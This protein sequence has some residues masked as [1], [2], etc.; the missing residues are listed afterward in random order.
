MDNSG[1]AQ[2]M[3]KFEAERLSEQNSGEAGLAMAAGAEG[4]GFGAQTQGMSAELGVRAV[5]AGQAREAEVLPG[6]AREQVQQLGWQVL[7]GG[8]RSDSVAEVGNVG[9]MAG[10]VVDFVATREIVRDQEELTQPEEFVGDE[11][12]LQIRE[13]LEEQQENSLNEINPTRDF[14][15]TIM[16]RGQEKIAQVAMGEVEGLLKKKEVHPAEIVEIWRKRGDAVLNSYENPH[17]IGKGN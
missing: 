9:Q 11:T 1:L 17:P 8:R 13:R 6:V 5:Q 12:E 14:E 3:Q 16:A 15:A 10:N 7:E 2:N 4:Q